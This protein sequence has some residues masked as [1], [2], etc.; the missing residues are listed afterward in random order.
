[1]AHVSTSESKWDNQNFGDI[2]D[3]ID[4]KDSQLA[5]SEKSSIHLKRSMRSYMVS[6]GFEEDIKVIFCMSH[7]MCSLLAEFEFIETDITYTQ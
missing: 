7:F 2:T 1:M 3:E 4:S 6:A 5:G